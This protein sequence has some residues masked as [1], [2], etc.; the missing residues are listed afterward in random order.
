VPT[1]FKLMGFRMARTSI[2]LELD[3]T[4]YD[5]RYF[6]DKGWFESDYFYPTRLG[7]LKKAA[8]SLFD[9]IQARTTRNRK[10]SSALSS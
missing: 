4:N 9:W 2:R 3:E 5:Y 6:K 8:G 1:F 10:K 7:I